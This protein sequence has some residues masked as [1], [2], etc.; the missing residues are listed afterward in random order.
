MVEHPAQAL[1]DREAEAEA[2][3]DPG[4]LIE[5]LELLEHRPAPV[6]GDADAGVPH[7]DPERARPP[8]AADQHL[9]LERILDGVRHQVLQEAAHQ[10]AIGADGGPGR[11][12]A[13]VEPFA[14]G[15][16]GELDLEHPHEIGDRNVGDLGPR[17]A[18]VEAR[19]VEER[20]EDLLDRLERHVDLAGEVVAVV[21]AAGPAP[22]ASELA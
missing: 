8:P 9:A 17:R 22:S 15:E 6:V 13:K 1:D 18:R 4:A 7:L 12:E 10:P 21:A 16:R 3:R 5:P 14:A 11:D 20:A 19:N 2:A